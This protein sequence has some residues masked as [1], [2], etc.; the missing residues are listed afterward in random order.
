MAGSPAV[1]ARG[2]RQTF[3]VGPELYLRS[4]E[5]SDADSAPIWNPS[6]IPRP[7]EVEK[8]RIEEQLGGDV[9][10]SLEHQRLLICR[11]SDGRPLGSVDFATRRD[12]T[13]Q[14]VF[15][16]DPN[17]SRDEW[18]R[19][20][21]ATLRLAVPW[22]LH[23]RSRMAVF[24]AFPGVHPLVEATTAE[25]GMRHC[26]RERERLVIAGERFDA[27]GYEALHPEWVA[28]LGLPRGMEEGPDVREVARPAPRAWV[29]TFTVPEPA[30]IVGERLYLRAFTPDDAELASHMLME[31]TEISFPEGREVVNPYVHARNIRETARQQLPA[32]LHLAIVLGETG[33]MIG[34]IGLIAPDL[35]T[36]VA[37]TETEIWK[38]EHRNKGYGTEAKHLLLEYAFDRLHLHMVVSLVSEFNTRS[39][40]A[41][42]K[43][44]YRD[45]GYLAW[46]NYHGVELYGM[47]IFDLLASEWRAARR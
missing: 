11:R 26:F 27:I 18:A 19:I 13:C 37:E 12:R 36:G 20:C 23:E 22:L 3:L 33:E 41:L 5:P 17:G 32:W 30:I 21:G 46:R 15:T 6:P 34:A 14:L 28:R 24:F 25:L 45:A 43:Q 47:L 4:L 31:E 8:E 38:A 35:V 40:A 44:G 16:Y 2:E 10:A 1:S 39:A 29:P 42:R 9:G 7:P